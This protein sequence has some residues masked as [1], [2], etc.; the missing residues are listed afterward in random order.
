MV[1]DCKK[2]KSL[3]LKLWIQLILKKCFQKKLFIANFWNSFTLKMVFSWKYYQT[4]V[5]KYL[6]SVQKPC[7][8][9]SKFWFR[10][11][12]PE[13]YSEMLQLLYSKTDI[14]C[15]SLII[16]SNIF[17]LFKLCHKKPLETFKRSQI[18]SY[19][20]YVRNFRK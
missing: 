19:F 5:F 13:I 18:K 1:W 4:T 9:W 11:L 3:S 10:W 2:I 12:Q 20:T 14:H 6:W 16:P 8:I 17:K 7:T 15:V